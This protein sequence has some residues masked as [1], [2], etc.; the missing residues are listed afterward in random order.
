[1]PK[2]DK[3]DEGIR[4]YEKRAKVNDPIALCQ[5]GNRC[6]E[7]GDFEGAFEYWKKAAELGSAESHHNLSLMY[8]K[9]EGVEKDEKKKVYHLEEAV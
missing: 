3:Q 1:M 8:H 9:G 4:N 2:V 5:L 7:E 6:D